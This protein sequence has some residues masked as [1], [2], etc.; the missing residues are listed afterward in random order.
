M[1]T[2]EFAALVKSRRSIRNWQ[3]KTVPEKMIMEAIEMATWAPNGGNRQNWRFFVVFNKDIIKALSD[4]M[5]SGAGARPRPAPPPGA[6]APA[7]RAPLSAAPVVIAIGITRT[8][9]PQDEAMARQALTDPVVAAQL[10]TLAAVD[11]PI[12]SI[13]A[14]ITTLLLALHQQ[15]LGAVWMC[16]PLT[17]CKGEFERILK[18][19]AGMD[20]VA[21]IPV[22][23]PAETPV[24]DR[25]PI[26]EV[27][28]IIR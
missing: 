27:C 5:Q 1:Q 20:I 17:N 26:A 28:D 14:A 13:A 21:F 8:T 2:A 23:F 7:P 3:D 11:T 22:G 16:G 4:A 15:G 24:K 6:P 12:Q 25:K 18:V 10:K 19:P 9:N